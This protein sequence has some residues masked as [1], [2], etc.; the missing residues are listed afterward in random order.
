MI[1]LARFYGW[2]DY[3]FVQ[4]W[5]DKSL[6]VEIEV[7]ELGLI[8]IESKAT[9]AQI[10]E[11]I[12]EN[13]I[14]KVSA[15]LH[16]LIKCMREHDN[17][18]KGEMKTMKKHLGIAPVLITI[19]SLTACVRNKKIILPKAEE[20]KEIEIMKNTSEDRLKI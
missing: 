17:K 7:D 12:L 10:K 13:L 11:Y 20:V 4:T 19:L 14:L 18:S 2:G 5:C 9:Y 1:R 3:T 6:N 8:G 15:W 16:R